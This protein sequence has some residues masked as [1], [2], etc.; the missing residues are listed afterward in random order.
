MQKDSHVFQDGPGQSTDVIWRWR[1]VSS[2][3]MLLHE[4]IAL[5]CARTGNYLLAPPGFHSPF[6]TS[7]VLTG[8]AAAS[9]AVLGD[10]YFYLLVGCDGSAKCHCRLSGLSYLCACLRHSQR[11]GGLNLGQLVG[12]WDMIKA[13]KDE[14][15]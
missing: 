7:P 5:S 10:S 2:N 12:N 1:G 15:A 8:K 6:P 13:R 11:C 3:V 14:I 4:V 9:C